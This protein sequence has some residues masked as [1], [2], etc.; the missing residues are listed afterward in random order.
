MIG[1]DSTNKANAYMAQIVEAVNNKDKTA[2]K[3][4]FSKKALSE[5]QDLDTNMDA[6]LVFIKGKIVSFDYTGG[7]GDNKFNYGHGYKSY[8]A[9]YDV[10]TDNHKY[11]FLIEEYTVD[12]DHPD[13]VGVY[14]IHVVKEEDK[15]GWENNPLITTA[16]IH[17]WV[18]TAVPSATGTATNP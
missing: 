18:P 7:S 3:S 4:I 13:N 11:L 16:G 14:I 15:A 12:T 8:G 9:V 17:I 10:N 6:L 1:D 2:L 5:A